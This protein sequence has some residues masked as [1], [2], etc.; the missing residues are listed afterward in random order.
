MT[1][2]QTCALPISLTNSGTG[3]MRYRCYV[4]GINPNTSITVDKPFTVSSATT[5]SFQSLKTGTALLKGWTV[6]N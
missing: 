2:V 4:T 3:T 1:G 6:T 5:L